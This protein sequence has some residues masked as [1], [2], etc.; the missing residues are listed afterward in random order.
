MPSPQGGVPE[1]HS[2]LSGTAGETHRKKATQK[3]TMT[4]S[5]GTRERSSCPSPVG[6]P[7]KPGWNIPNRNRRGSE[8]A[9]ELLPTLPQPYTIRPYVVSTTEERER[10][11]LPPRGPGRM[12][13]LLS[14]SGPAHFY[15]FVKEI[16]PP[17]HCTPHHHHHHGPRLSA[18]QSTDGLTSC[19]RVLQMQVS[20]GLLG[21]GVYR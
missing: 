7:L 20:Y 9:T 12:W 1:S 14:T 15:T 18:P 11:C 17:P 19:H 16:R 13:R 10:S 2:T 6:V 4:N 3:L 8:F 21:V 5:R